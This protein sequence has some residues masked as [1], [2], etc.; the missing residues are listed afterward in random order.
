MALVAS[1]AK[2]KSVK[3][4]TFDPFAAEHLPL[5]KMRMKELKALYVK[6]PK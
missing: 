5:P 1:V 6:K 2:G 4:S 3:P